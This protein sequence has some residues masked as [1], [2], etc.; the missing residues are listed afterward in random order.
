MPR[1]KSGLSLQPYVGRSP[2]HP[3]IHPMG[4][5]NTKQRVPRDM[6]SEAILNPPIVSYGSACIDEP[7]T[8]QFKK[9]TYP[10]PKEEGGS[11]IHMMWT[12]S[13]CRLTC[14]NDGMRTVEALRNSKIECIVAQ[15][16]WL[17]NDCLFADILLPVNTNLEEEDIMTNTRQ[18]V[19][20]QS[21]AYHE[22]AMQPLGESKTDLE[23]VLEIAK[24][25][26]MHDKIAGGKSFEEL[27]KTTYT[28]LGLDAFMDWEQFR[29]KKYFTFPFVKD[30]EKDPAGMI[31]FY[32][33]PE[34]NPLPTPSGKLEFYSES[35]AK[36]FPDD[37][38]RPPIPKWIEKGVT[39]DERLSGDRARAYPLIMISNHPRWRTH[40]QGDDISWTRETPTCKVKGW[41]GYL[42]E[43]VWINPQDAEARGIKDGDIV[44]IFNEKGIVLAGARVWERL[45]K[46]ATYVDHGSRC[47]WIIPGK[48]D[49]GGAINLI[50]PSG[51]SSKN[52]LGMA[53]S[54]YL[55]DVQKVS[56]AQMEEWKTEYPEA[57]A[58]EYDPAA[59]LRFDTWVEGGNS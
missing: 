31:K 51:T 6:I 13:P 46:G 52:A 27:M 59:G 56:M 49:R 22:Q 15:H 21:A 38:E 40:A 11:E 10:I 44:K 2:A 34:N 18:G 17:E 41:D 39:H 4:K 29:E 43:P 37:K 8:D 14:W 26:G 32:Q 50:S 25:L 5:I 30:W 7:T 28:N 57:F 42:Y 23:V 1:N 24:K 48:L 47:D 54:G 33:N 58:R 3:D 45:I 9:Y 16:Q 35:L 36:H 12:D 20:F 53:E 55:V 19:Q